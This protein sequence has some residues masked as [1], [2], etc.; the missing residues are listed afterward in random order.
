MDQAAADLTALVNSAAFK[1]HMKCLSKDAKLKQHVDQLNKVIK[2]ILAEVKLLQK[3]MV[4]AKQGKSKD[5][6]K[7]M[8]LTKQMLEHLEEFAELEANRD[9]IEYSVKQCSKELIDVTT[10]QKDIKKQSLATLRKRI[11]TLTANRR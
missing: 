1:S 6:S 7:L 3:E 4:A 10:L 2:Q 5:L 11:E 9:L 8:T